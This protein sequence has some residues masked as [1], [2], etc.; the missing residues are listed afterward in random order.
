MRKCSG[1]V[2]AGEW[3]WRYEKVRRGEC[4][5]GERE[6]SQQTVRGDANASKRKKARNGK[7]DKI[8]KMFFSSSFF[9]EFH[10]WLTNAF[11][12]VSFFRS[13]VTVL[14]C[15]VVVS[16]SLLLLLLLLLL[17]FS[18]MNEPMHSVCMHV[19]MC[20][21]VDR[22]GLC[23]CVCVCVL[24]LVILALVL[25]L[26]LS[27]VCAPL[28]SSYCLQ[29]SFLRSFV[30]SSCLGSG[31]FW[32]VVVTVQPFL[33]L[34]RSHFR[35]LLCPSPSFP[36]TTSSLFH[37]THTHSLSLLLILHESP[38]PSPFAFF[39]TTPSVL[40]R[41]RFLCFDTPSHSNSTRTWISLSSFSFSF[42]FLSFPSNQSI[43]QLINEDTIG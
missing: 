28:C 8:R 12:R 11:P 10:L 13:F 32:H 24:C 6:E 29:L 4:W 30:R 26:S 38:P 15:C 5:G 43:N 31:F 7:F 19:C 25:L 1:R 41:A 18:W 36:T 23:V 17:S 14:C 9:K 42:P 39:P 27:F 20:G 21:W 33:P 40:A 35:S 37:Y 34:S 2:K 3:L 22:V 16:S